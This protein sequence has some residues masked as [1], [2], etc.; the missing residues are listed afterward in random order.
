MKMK[1]F[2]ATF[3][4]VLINGF[5]CWWIGFAAGQRGGTKKPRAFVKLW[6]DGNSATVHSKTIGDDIKMIFGICAH[7]EGEGYQMYDVIEAL[8]EAIKAGNTK[9]EV[10][11]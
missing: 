5:V 7:I 8:E 2:I 10:E 9:H 3:I 1:N 6:K 11:E 4:P